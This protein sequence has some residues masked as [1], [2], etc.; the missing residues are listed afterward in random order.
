MCSPAGNAARIVTILCCGQTRWDP[1]TQTHSLHT[2]FSLLLTNSITGSDVNT[3]SHDLTEAFLTPFPHPPTPLH[4]VSW[5]EGGGLFHAT[6]Y[7]RP[8]PS[9]VNHGVQG[10][11]PAEHKMQPSTGFMTYLGTRP[12]MPCCTFL[13]ILGVL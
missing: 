13:L 11:I 2:A 10:R 4:A 7:C 5:E 6:L 8:V 12:G 9:G 3:D 1:F